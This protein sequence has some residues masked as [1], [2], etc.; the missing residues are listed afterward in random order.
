MKKASAQLSSFRRWDL[1]PSLALLA[2]PFVFVL[3]A[4][5]GAHDGPA[6]R[7]TLAEL[8]L[9][10]YALANL[11]GL[12]RRRRAPFSPILLLV[13]GLVLAH[14]VSAVAH[15]SPEALLKA[16]QL[17]GSL[18][19][20][21]VAL[22]HALARKG[23]TLA[24]L[25]RL[26]ALAGAL[27]GLLAGVQGLTGTAAF[28]VRGGLPDNQLYGL[29]ELLCFPFL[30]ISIRTCFEKQ[31]GIGWGVIGAV[32]TGLALTVHDPGLLL[33]LAMEAALLALLPAA[34]ARRWLAGAALVLLMLGPHAAWHGAELR[35]FA[36]PY[37]LSDISAAYWRSFYL[38]NPKLGTLS[39]L[40]LG[41]AGLKVDA[42]ILPIRA[43]KAGQP[44]PFKTDPNILKQRYAEWAA[45]A[46]MLGA[47]P[48][49]GV[50][51]GNY[52]GRI[53]E[54]YS[55][56]AKLNTAEP[57]TQNGWLVLGSSVGLPAMLALLAA[58]A[59][60]LA[61]FI[62]IRKQNTAISSSH[63]SEPYR[64]A[65]AASSLGLLWGGLWA[66][67]AQTGLLIPLAALLAAS[68]EAIFSG[69]H[70]GLGMPR[71]SF[72]HFPQV[73]RRLTSAAFGLG[74]LIILASS[75]FQRQ[76]SRKVYLWREAEKA[77]AI[78][79]PV[80]LQADGEASGGVG[81]SI[82]AGAGKGWRGEAGGSATFSFEL[83][84]TG[85]YNVWARTRWHDGCANTFFL[86]VSGGPRLILGNDA[87][88]G[89]WHWIKAASQRL[90]K[91]RAA[92]ELAN[93]ED[94]VALDKLLLT[95]DLDFEP[96]GSWEQVFSRKLGERA[97]VG[98]DAGG[99]SAWQ[100]YDEKGIRGRHLPLASRAGQDRLLLD[101][102]TQDSF[103]LDCAFR[104]LEGGGELGLILL[105]QDPANFVSLDLTRER[106]QLHR[107][108]DGKPELLAS[109]KGPLAL[110]PG[111]PATVAILYRG[112]I[113][114][115]GLN[116]Q[117]LLEHIDRR[118]VGGR[119]GFG[120]QRGGVVV[121]SFDLRPLEGI[122]G[123]R[124]SD[125]LQEAAATSRTVTLGKADW[126]NL[127]ILAQMEKGA[128]PAWLKFNISPAGD[129]FIK[130]Q[131]EGERFK[132]LG[133]ERG[134]ETES[135]F[136]SCS[137]QELA[138][139]EV[140]TVRAIDHEVSLLVD[141]REMGRCELSKASPIKGSIELPPA[142]LRR[143]EVKGIS[144]FYDGFGGCD[145]GNSASWSAER[146]QWKVI[147][148]PV[149]GLEDCYAQT[150]QGVGLALAGELFWENYEMSA[151]VSSGGEEGIGIVFHYLDEKNC[152]F[153]RWAGQEST[154]PYGG[155]LQLVRRRA[156]REEVVASAAVPLEIERW[157]ELRKVASRGRE[158]VMVNGREVLSAP[159]DPAGGRGR[160]GLF[161]EN[162]P[163][164]CFDNVRVDRY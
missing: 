119:C 143:V 8:L 3:T 25:G 110:A 70:V 9:G 111:Q 35:R 126:G 95:S 147:K 68:E 91:G 132:V 105:Y 64:I 81:I 82:P 17:A 52:Q 36:S 39:R 145:G 41:R 27:M 149:A 73:G 16:L 150:G 158:I 106:A 15:F 114:T 116:G 139:A 11:R 101:S 55:P 135:R 65:V 12:W 161:C 140:L 63:E 96:E 60:G 102:P 62:P 162:N 24:K 99:P 59:C 155:R 87:V 22:R 23:L 137:R 1:L 18:L 4:S 133:V 118:L 112:G 42:A 71:P 14:L 89:Q 40:A 76:A 69:G 46:A 127:S 131:R 80:R 50:G 108:R 34:G 152:E 120:S 6:L 98:W 56:M 30:F 7:M 77:D 136:I 93:R 113:I 117:P 84:E 109:A 29:F 122:Y 103:R 75:M 72:P 88:F 153:V 53:G 144:R 141:G 86:R 90:A 47:S 163:L 159:E 154:L 94:G 2:M 10:L 146:G 123:L 121:E 142:G 57:D 21:F 138:R 129:R 51:P 125:A 97:L 124:E 107:T 78:T 151:M 19:L 5:R 128:C 92:L 58:L 104:L 74:A 32:A 115:A 54:F 156:G 160:V 164:A 67:L 49:V 38:A 33:G 20:G 28:F 31:K 61:G 43:E 157:Y 134:R 83:P 100:G 66:P 130:I 26:L 45:A 13:L 148:D 79:P 44:E 37:E 85:L 48:A